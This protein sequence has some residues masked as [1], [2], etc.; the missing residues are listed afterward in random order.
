[1]CDGNKLKIENLKGVSFWSS[2]RISYELEAQ[3]VSELFGNGHSKYTWT[4]L[5]TFKA[6]SVVLSDTIITN[7]NYYVWLQRIICLMNWMQALNYDIKLVLPWIH[8]HAGGQ[9]LRANISLEIP[10]KCFFFNF[11]LYT[12]TKWSIYKYASNRKIH[13]HNNWC[14]LRIGQWRFGFIPR[15]RVCCGLIHPMLSP[16]PNM[17]IIVSI[18]LQKMNGPT[19]IWWINNAARIRN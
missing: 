15:S 9:K 13:T 14:A 7:N 6:L 4:R 2:E 18:H 3:V 8:R 19:S 12:N 11:I 16:P 17:N 10:E 1:M 5:K